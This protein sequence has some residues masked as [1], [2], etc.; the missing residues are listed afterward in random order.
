M[1]RLVRAIHVTPWLKCQRL[2]SWCR[3]ILAI[4]GAVVA[5]PALAQ[6]AAD[7]GFY[8][9]KQIKV[10]VGFPPGGGFDAYARTLADHMGRHIPGNP[11]FVVQHMPGA[12]TAKAAAHIYG[13]AAQDGTF[14]GLFHQ[15]LLANQ[16]LDIQGGSF[17]VT[18]FNWIG[19]MGTRLSVGLVWHTTG[20]KTIEDARKTE[21]IMG[22]TSPTATSAMVPLALNHA[23][24]TKFKVVQGYQGSADM[25]LAMERGETHGLPIAGWLDLT[26]PRAD[27][28]KDGKV[29][30]LYQIALE[31]HA[32]LPNVPALADLA[33]NSDDKQIL[34][35][36]ASTEDMG[37][38]FVAGPGVPEAR[39][40]VLRAS[41]AAMMADPVFLAD[42]RKRQLDIDFLSGRDLQ[43][44]VRSV[45]AFPPDVAAK[46]KQILK[47]TAP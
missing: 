27:W 7:D 8:A 11:G 37:R 9:G 20:V 21:I 25:Y 2:M 14:M 19:R 28:I 26:G 18:R 36:L 23:A 6:P 40:D 29:A 46:A 44:M 4:A 22:A 45:G 12:T 24:G 33:T 38:S 41:F 16:V 13:V 39:V 30:V 1:A 43:A 32:D 35:L 3:R 34:S 5:V 17:D 31:R 10:I 15:G 42:A 47:P